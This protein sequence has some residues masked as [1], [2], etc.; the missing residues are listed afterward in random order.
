MQNDK[1][2]SMGQEPYTP[3]PR[4]RIYLNQ[5]EQGSNKHK[6]AAA[7]G[8]DQ[9]RLDKARQNEEFH[10]QVASDARQQRRAVLAE[11]TDLRNQLDNALNVMRDRQEEV[12]RLHRLIEQGRT[13][14]SQMAHDGGNFQSQLARGQ[15]QVDSLVNRV[16]T[17]QNQV[18]EA[19]AEAL[20]LQETLRARDHQVNQLIAEVQERED[21]V[22][23]LRLQIKQNGRAKTQV[24]QA[25]RGGRVSKE[26]FPPGRPNLLDLAMDPAPLPGPSLDAPRN[27][28]MEDFAAKLDVDP[29][30]LAKFVTAMKLM[31]GET[32]HINVSPGKSTQRRK[33]SRKSDAK[34]A[35]EPETQ[36]LVNKAHALMREMTYAR[37]GVKQATDFI[38]H[39][40]ATEEE[41][42]EFAQDD[43]AA[44][45]RYQFDFGVDYKSSAWNAAVMERLVADVVR[46]D[47]LNMRYIQKELISPEYLGYILAEQLVRYRADWKQFQPKWDEEKGRVE[48]E[49]EAVAR[50]KIV[51]FNRRVSSRTVNGQHMKFDHRRNTVTATIA[52]KESEGAD[53][54]ATWERLLEILDLLGAG[55]MSEEEEFNSLDNGAKVRKYIVKLCVWREPLIVDYM[56]IIDKQTSRFQALHN[57]TKPAPR[58]RVETPGKR[59][60]PKGL[61]ACLYNSEWMAS[62]S[63]LELKE[64]K[65]SKKVFALFVAATS[66]MA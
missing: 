47:S 42:E 10:K 45:Q 37:F 11:N 65:I 21:E 44:F 41:V 1:D 27:P 24:G 9:E 62:L 59:Y 22:E 36:E 38:F 55:G 3:A 20:R 18:A 23:S 66:R 63:L 57:G 15:E 33:A 7:P 54:L 19:S 29:D 13:L 34:A 8:P 5:D 60:A 31:N 49:A 4:I 52:L 26:F 40:P 39:I 61:P 43:E 53:D 14:I 25:K 16:A 50:G 46:E 28:V 30:L 51:L 35:V 6:R 17:A 12:A 58:V 64:L 32:A 2:D 56:S 48:T